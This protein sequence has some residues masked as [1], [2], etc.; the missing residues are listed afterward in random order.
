AERQQPEMRNV[1]CQMLNARMPIST[2]LTLQAFGIR[3][4]AFGIW[5]L[6]FGHGHY[7]VTVVPTV[8]PITT[9]RRLP[10]VR[11]LK[12]TIGSLL[13]MHREIAVASITLS[14]C[15]RTLR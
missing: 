8:S 10:G 7:A 12:T 2:L 15:S 6:P 3:H 4:L 13:S 14:P 5:H 1:K 11:R 9:R